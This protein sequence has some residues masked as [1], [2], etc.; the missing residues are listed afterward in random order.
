MDGWG[1]L[2][3]WSCNSTAFFLQFLFC[4]FSIELYPAHGRRS[5]LFFSLGF[6]MVGMGW[7]GLFLLVDFYFHFFIFFW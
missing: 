5:L 6:G 4:P 1:W 3:I 7:V 2:V